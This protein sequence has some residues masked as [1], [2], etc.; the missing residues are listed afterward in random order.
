MVKGNL[1]KICTSFLWL[2]FCVWCQV[3]THLLDFYNQFILENTVL[4]ANWKLSSPAGGDCLP[5]GGNSVTKWYWNKAR[6]AFIFLLM[7]QVVWQ[8]IHPRHVTSPDRA[9]CFWPWSRTWC[10]YKYRV[11]GGHC[12]LPQAHSP[13]VVCSWSW[14]QLLSPPAKLLLTKCRK[15]EWKRG[16]EC[17]G[18]QP[19]LGARLGWGEGLSQSLESSR[20]D[21]QWYETTV[22]F[23]GYLGIQYILMN[24]PNSIL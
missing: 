13:L 1:I 2:N 9:E 4:I 23:Y 8:G 24:L 22:Y 18:A 20:F 11:L 19:G 12:C 3:K 16:T 21:M 7:K 10:L 5:Y 6:H 14:L 15:E 17:P